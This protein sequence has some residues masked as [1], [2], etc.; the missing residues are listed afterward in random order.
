MVSGEQHRV[1]LIDWSDCLLFVIG[2]VNQT[3]TWQKAVGRNLLSSHSVPAFS[4]RG[5]RGGCCALLV[6]VLATGKTDVPISSDQSKVMRII[7][8]SQKRKAVRKQMSKGTSMELGMWWITRRVRVRSAQIE[9]KFKYIRALMGIKARAS[10][11]QWVMEQ[12]NGPLEVR[13][14]SSKRD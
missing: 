10:K 9:S 13:G 12:T 4:G 1:E 11:N 8:S 7:L 3:S 6:V 5:L 14:F 2:W